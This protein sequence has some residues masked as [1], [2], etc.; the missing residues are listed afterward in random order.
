MGKR[1]IR[2]LTFFL[3]LHSFPLL[4]QMR[5]RDRDSANAFPRITRMVADNQNNHTPKRGILTA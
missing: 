5:F 2:M 3:F 1:K 4:H